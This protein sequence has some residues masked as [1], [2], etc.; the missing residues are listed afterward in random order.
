[1]GIFDRWRRRPSVGA[2]A[3]E[4][5]STSEGPQDG[6][7]DAVEDDGVDDVLRGLIVPGFTRFSDAVRA[8]EELLEDDGGD[9]A[10]GARRARAIWEARAA[11]LGS[12]SGPSDHDRLAGAFAVLE[13]DH[14]FV[15]AMC[16]GFDRGELW[17]ELRERRATL[18]NTAWA[19]VG[20]HQQD[21]E[22]LATTPATLYLLSSVFAPNPETPAVVVDEV[23][24]S[25]AGRRAMAETDA[26]T[27]AGLLL[28]AL[29]D[30]GLEASW[31]GSTG[32]RV[33]VTI[34]DWR[35]PLPTD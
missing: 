19:G 35:K 33:Q 3:R 31:D 2:D 34:D 15:T 26:A 9:V 7:V 27:V 10:S 1:M 20:F 23:M 14:G 13:R 29:R 17:E 32:S 5:R 24:R 4:S 28:E 11:E 30:A 18:G 25:E 8:A 22:R 12:S 21:A 16:A 6:P